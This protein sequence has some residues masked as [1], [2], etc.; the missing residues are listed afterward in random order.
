METKKEEEKKKDDS[1][2]KDLD[3]EKKSKDTDDS[4]MTIPKDKWNQLYAR[5]SEA[6]ELKQKFESMELEKNE[7]EKRKLEDEK[8]FEELYSQSKKEIE[9]LQI[10]VKTFDEQHAVLEDILNKR[11]EGIVENKR[12][13]IP[14][15][16]STFQ[17]LK[18]IEENWE[19][20]GE[21][22]KP[23]DQKQTPASGS[24][25]TDISPDRLRLNDLISKK[26]NGDRLTQLEEN[27]VIK[28]S[29]TFSEK[30]RQGIDGQ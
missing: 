29:Q 2:D 4:M 23:A 12:K 25:K 6:K 24:S 26:V 30:S 20:L 10:K 1:G 14:E 16:Y 18:Y 22:K 8:K 21:D 5:A 19:I 15:S 9:D 11:V 7:A 13:L 27:E 3:K 28:L 17:K